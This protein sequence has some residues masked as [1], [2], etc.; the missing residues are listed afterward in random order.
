MSPA[1]WAAD[2]AHLSYGAANHTRRLRWTT[3]RTLLDDVRGR[4][5]RFAGVASRRHRDP[6]DQHA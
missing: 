4:R 6:A 5:S 1:G 2:R 3:D